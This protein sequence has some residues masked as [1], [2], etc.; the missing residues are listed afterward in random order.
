M[1]GRPRRF[2][3]SASSLN[4]VGSQ[5]RIGEIQSNQIAW[6]S[7]WIGPR[8]SCKIET[9]SDPIAVAVRVARAFG[10]VGAGAL[11]ISREDWFR[12]SGTDRPGECTIELAFSAEGM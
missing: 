1:D 5:I 3:P 10:G 8:R 11:V 9:R 2:G 4:H 7:N 6:K 12:V